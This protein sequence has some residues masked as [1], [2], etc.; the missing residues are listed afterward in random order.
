MLQ[1]QHQFSPYA[2]IKN[3]GAALPPCGRMMRAGVAHGIRA[4]VA[5]QRGAALFAEVTCKKGYV[6]PTVR[7][8]AIG[9]LNL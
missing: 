6:A 8:D 7:A 1:R 5:L 3:S 2:F 9:N 4:K